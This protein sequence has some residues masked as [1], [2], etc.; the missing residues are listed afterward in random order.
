MYS[1]IAAATCLI[2]WGFTLFSLEHGILS[3]LV[4]SLLLVIH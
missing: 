1:N 3:M 2:P 4:G